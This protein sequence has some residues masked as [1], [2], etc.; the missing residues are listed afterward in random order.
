[1]RG[2]TQPATTWVGFGISLEALGRR[3]EA[4]QAYRRALAA[5]ALVGDH[6]DPGVVEAELQHRLDNLSTQPAG[7]IGRDLIDSRP[8][9]SRADER[10]DDLLRPSA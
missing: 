8:I 9:E 4:A 6:R 10:V 2:G 1:M 5:V 7:R 3:P